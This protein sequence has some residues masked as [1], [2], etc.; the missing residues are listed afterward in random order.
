MSG[1]TF[2]V[3]FEKSKLWQTL[4][5]ITADLKRKVENSGFVFLVASRKLHRRGKML[6]LV[7][8]VCWC[9]FKGRSVKFIFFFFN[10]QIWLEITVMRIR[11]TFHSACFLL[12]RKEKIC[13][14]KTKYL[15]EYF[16]YK[17]TS[18]NIESW[19]HRMA[20]SCVFNWKFFWVTCAIVFLVIW[21]SN[22]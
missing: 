21:V 3:K 11:C 20:W 14:Y 10:N 9:M 8:C 7:F 5:R 18:K 13:L 16:C 19:N 6:L 12:H 15:G 1:W 17:Y 4:R 22:T 2:Q